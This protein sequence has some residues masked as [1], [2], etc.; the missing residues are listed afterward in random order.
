MSSR[1]IL[2]AEA[3]QVAQAIYEITDSANIGA[4]LGMTALA[5][6]FAFSDKA[7][8]STGAAQRL[9]ARSGAFEFKSK[10][11]FAVMAMGKKNNRYDGEAIFI[12]RGTD[13][14]Y[15]WLTD[16]NYAVVL[17]ASGTRVHAGFNRTF[18]DMKDAIALF[19]AQ[20]N[21][22]HVHC[23]GHSLGGALA[24]LVADW[25]SNRGYGV[26]LYTFGSPR[27]GTQDFADK[28][29]ARVGRGNIYRV[30]H[31]SDPVS[32]VPVWPYL[33]AP[34]PDGEC[35]VSRSA[36]VNPATHRIDDYINT[37][38]R[39]KTWN[40]LYCPTP[41]VI[42]EYSVRL[43][44]AETLFAMLTTAPLLAFNMVIRKICEGIAITIMPGMSLLDQMSM[45]VESAANISIEGESLVRNFLQ[46]LVKVM[47]LS[48]VIPQKI[49]HGI[50]K[51]IFAAFTRAAYN[52][53]L[54]ASALVFSGL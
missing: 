31:S 18:Q 14:V 47:G 15:D 34:R 11:G 46:A 12:C 41:S 4:A 23:V 36:S 53:A 38:S 48:I 19:L 6:F 3:A 27:V 44:S 45:W 17:G 42:L 40:E 9:T 49:M 21:P 10:T 8:P 39:S 22:R 24:T 43:W 25:L 7:A 16:A 26:D 1:K 20:N 37:I 52:Q 50:I 28:L 33:H 51:L 13:S 54:R 5:E 35:W 30:C 2:P 29:T 32:L